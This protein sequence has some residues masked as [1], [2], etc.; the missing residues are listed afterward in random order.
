MNHRRDGLL[1]G[2][3]RFRRDQDM[4]VNTSLTGPDGD[5]TALSRLR[6]RLAFRR[7]RH[8]CRGVSQP[9]DKTESNP[10]GDGLGL[11]ACKRPHDLGGGSGKHHLIGTARLGSEANARRLENQPS[12]HRGRG[13]TS[14]ES[15]VVVRRSFSYNTTSPPQ[16]HLGRLQPRRRDFSPP[17]VARPLAL[18]LA[19]ARSARRF[20]RPTTI[21]S[22]ATA[23]A[24]RRTLDWPPLG[25]G[26]ARPCRALRRVCGVQGCEVQREHA[27]ASVVPDGLEL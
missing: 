23:A 14:S 18:S 2:R 17:G 21:R 25:S 4:P 6:L 9:K 10:I 13:S 24:S 16:A 22:V 26:R 27:S 7:P 19:P 3:P 20:V 5:A 12:T 1:R 15:C 11:L 8:R